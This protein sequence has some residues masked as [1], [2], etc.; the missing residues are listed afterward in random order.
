MLPA[1]YAQHESSLVGVR[2]SAGVAIG[3]PARS[4]TRS[5]VIFTASGEYS[6]RALRQQ[7]KEMVR[8]GMHEMREVSD[9]RFISAVSSMVV[10]KPVSCVFASAIFLDEDLVDI[11]QH[12]EQT[13]SRRN[14]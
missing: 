7:L 14:R 9:Y 12:A 3:I 5:G 2:I 1:V 6:D 8:E 13:A 11:V 10:L 4:D